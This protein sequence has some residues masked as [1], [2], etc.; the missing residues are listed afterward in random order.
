MPKVS[1]LLKLLKVRSD[2]KFNDI[3]MLSNHVVLFALAVRKPNAPPAAS[4]MP[5]P[6][7]VSSALS[8][9][10]SGAGPPQIVHP[11]HLYTNTAATVIH[12]TYGGPDTATYVNVVSQRPP[13]FY[14]HPPPMIRPQVQPHPSS[15]G[16][17]PYSPAFQSHQQHV[18]PVGIAMPRQ[19]N[20]DSGAAYQRQSSIGKNKIQAHIF[21]SNPSIRSF[22]DLQNP[23]M[24][25]S[26]RHNLENLISCISH[27]QM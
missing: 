24:Q 19:G 5:M 7:V 9:S 20:S 10:S 23:Q 26:S 21:A 2:A 22:F 4:S 3:C 8:S 1:S 15:S 27:F 17:V 12:P 16:H 25:G 13:P 14:H 6:N 11:P 18:R